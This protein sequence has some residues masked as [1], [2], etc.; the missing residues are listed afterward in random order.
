M[1]PTD[2]D[3]ICREIRGA[4]KHHNK[5]IGREE[6]ILVEHCENMARSG[7]VPPTHLCERLLLLYN[8]KTEPRRLKGGNIFTL[9]RR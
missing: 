5:R 4:V 7:K 1:Q 2:I 6:I 9:P 3:W 8:R